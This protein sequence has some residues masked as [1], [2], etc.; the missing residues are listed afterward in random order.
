MSSLLGV[1][2]LSPI[3][4]SELHCSD[5]WC[6]RLDPQERGLR[7]SIVAKGV[8]L[9]CSGFCLRTISMVLLRNMENILGLPG[10]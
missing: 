9:V 3:W 5:A 7:T 6:T 1:A 4:V 2:K 8:M 10:D